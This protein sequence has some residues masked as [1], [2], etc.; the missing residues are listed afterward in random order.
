MQL[1]VVRSSSRTFAD[2]P[3]DLPANKAICVH[4]NGFIE[5]L[6][7]KSLSSTFILTNTSYLTD[8][9]GNSRWSHLFREDIEVA[10]A[11][12]FI[13]FSLYDLDIARVLFASS[14][15]RQKCCFVVSEAPSD[16]MVFS[17]SRFGTVVPVGAET[18]GRTLAE[19]AA[20]HIPAA[21]PRMFN[22][23]RA[24]SF[25]TGTV[26]SSTDVFNLYVKGESRSGST[27]SR[28]R[29]CRARL[30]CSATRPRRRRRTPQS[31]RCSARGTFVPWERQNLA[32]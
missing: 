12:L 25:T 9:F 14:R 8:N 16:E 6:D 21:P 15:I 23:F 4:I 22:S 24:R 3:S 18:A 1:T 28:I 13:G 30:L 31:R 20:T 10:R 32:V 27:T 19:L 2:S 7:V 11:V 17:L 5:S 26:P 29:E